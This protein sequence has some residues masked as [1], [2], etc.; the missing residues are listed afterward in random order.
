[1]LSD[2]QFW[3]PT[4][5]QMLGARYE[6]V[7]ALTER[8]QEINGARV[9]L[10]QAIDTS[11]SRPVLLY[12]MGPGDPRAGTILAAARQAAANPDPRFIRVLDAKQA[13]GQELL[14]FVATEFPAGSTLTQLL[15]D[16]PLTNAE[17][18]YI[19]QQVAEALSVPH[20]NGKFHRHLGPHSVFITEG[21]DI[22]IT[23]FLVDAA[24]SQDNPQAGWSD[25]QNTDLRQLGILLYACLTGCLPIDPEKEQRSLS[26]LPAAPLKGS[27]GQQTWVDPQSIRPSAHVGLNKI[28]MMLLIHE[29]AKVSF[30]TSG[31]VAA[32]LKRIIGP[33]TP[34][35]EL[36]S[37]MR[38]FKPDQHSEFDE[39]TEIQSGKQDDMAT[40]VVPVLPAMLEN[41][42]FSEPI[43][44]I[45]KESPNK[46]DQ[47]YPSQG[48]ELSWNTK[49]IGRWLAVLVIFLAVVIGVAIAANMKHN[50]PEAA[51]SP[52][53]TATIASVRVFD[54]VADGGDDDEQKDL[55]PL[56]TD[57][58]STTAWQTWTYYGSSK[59]GNIK[60]GAGLLID[61]GSDTQLPDVH[62]LLETSPADVQLMVP[63]ENPGTETAP[64]DSVNQWRVVA[65]VPQ[66]GSDV[67]L[68]SEE[69]ITS[70]WVLVYFTN[71]PPIAD[72]QFR[73]GIL[74]MS[75]G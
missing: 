31:E 25:Q 4:P 53:A 51:S 52:E 29:Y 61:L 14:S 55:V 62:L 74:E 42:E 45:K 66:A 69:E 36:E 57:G 35:E 67:T 33:N 24:I 37:R 18:A 39:V 21:G 10:W 26:G 15:L 41:P 12:V 73:T 7:E 22:K 9:F 63:A 8:G 44:D 59:F 60:P 30:A 17:S 75:L 27:G 19:V 38:N 11:L 20:S 49:L 46:P 6:L 13:E 64:M 54:P 43:G 16:G 50:Q 72:G 68:H 34:M 5:G 1:M 48:D 3:R 65:T 58:D 56:A 28:A 70:R 40:E 71:L 32:A 47:Q 23:G 2:N